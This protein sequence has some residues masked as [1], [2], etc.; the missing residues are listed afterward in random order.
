MPQVNPFCFEIKMLFNFSKLMGI[1]PLEAVGDCGGCH[2]MVVIIS[3]TMAGSKPPL[4]ATCP[5][6]QL[7]EAQ[8]AFEEKQFHGK[9]VIKVNQS[10]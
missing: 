6:A 5:L 7:H 3:Q 4:S 2:R 10:S 8:Q 1:R 9:I